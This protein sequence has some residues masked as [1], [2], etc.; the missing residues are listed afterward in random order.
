MIFIT[1]EFFLP[2]NSGGSIASFNYFKKY[3]NQET[4]LIAYFDKNKYRQEDLKNRF[5]KEFSIK[6]LELIPFNIRIRKNPLAL[7]RTVALM[8]GKQYPY[9][10]AKFY[11]KRLVSKVLGYMEKD[12]IDTVFIDHLNLAFLAPLIKK[13][14]PGIR[15]MKISHNNESEIVQNF[16]NTRKGLIKKIA[17]IDEKLIHR[18]QKHHHVFFDQI[19][20][21][22][23]VDA[24]NLNTRLRTKKFKYDPM[25]FYFDRPYAYRALIKDTVGVCGSLSWLPNIQGIEWYLDYIHP[26]LVKERKSYQFIIAGSGAGDNLMKKWN[27]LKR[28][29]Y[30][31]Y[32]KNLK[33][34][35]EQCKVI[36]VP[37]LSGSGIRIKI[38][39]AFSYSVP[40][41]AT[42]KAAQGLNI[43]H[44]QEALL[45]N[46]PQNFTY[47]VNALLDNPE[48][49]KVQSRKAYDFLKTNHG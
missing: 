43:T 34:F 39:D 11:S 27:G 21:I 4:I 32:V 41:V 25:P 46:D 30:L 40:I 12:S 16:A 20:C 10:A 17:D 18:F 36:V 19:K 5:K 28:V 49:R 38:L 13:I 2:K 23:A 45:S 48:K 14:K 9:L 37:L 33:T 6:R 7:I 44:E 3:H 8:L 31:G 29:K 26:R 15:L 1:T 35:Y 42:L 47:Y 24:Q 22:S